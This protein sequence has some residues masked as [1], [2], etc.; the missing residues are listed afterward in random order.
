MRRLLYVQVQA[1]APPARAPD[2][3][4]RRARAPERDLLTAGASGVTLR[5]D[6][7]I[8]PRDS[9]GPGPGASPYSGGLARMRWELARCAQSDID[10]ELFFPEK[11]ASSR[12][13]RAICAECPI[14]IECLNYAIFHRVSD[15]IWG[16]RSPDQRKTLRRLAA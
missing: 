2:R 1:R 14:Q 5:Q 12:R 15:G 8:C 9:E 11:G 13:A 7:D 10:P 6:G 4:S 3:G 16:G